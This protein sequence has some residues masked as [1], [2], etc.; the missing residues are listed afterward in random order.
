MTT[1][2]LTEAAQAA[3]YWE[4]RAR[5]WKK[6]AKRWRSSAKL[7]ETGHYFLHRDRW[8]RQMHRAYGTPT[9]DMCGEP[10]PDGGRF[11]D[12]VYARICHSCWQQE[13][14]E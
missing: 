8:T 1:A 14:G 6:A 12:G 3:R 13:L 7:W 9:C 5:C 10:V 4:K 11:K 2:Q